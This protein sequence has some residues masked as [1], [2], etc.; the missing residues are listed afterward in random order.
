MGIER[1][2]CKKEE[3]KGYAIFSKTP[4]ESS[5]DED[6]NG[7]DQFSEI[8]EM[9]G[10]ISEPIMTQIDAIRSISNSPTNSSVSDVT[11]LAKNP[12]EVADR[13]KR[14]M[15]AFLI[16]SK[17]NRKKYQELHPGRDNRRITTLLAEDWNRMKEEDKKPYKDEADDEMRR[18]KENP[19]FK[20]CEAKKSP[21]I[22]V[23]LTAEECSD[24]F[25]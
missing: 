12:G 7:T 5:E 3:K 9:C 1:P 10:M 15:N 20:Y 24:G 2:A 25:R 8:K 4:S 17:K 23:C 22:T 18:K 14:P 11:A 13:V 16:F 21:R 19:K 6:S